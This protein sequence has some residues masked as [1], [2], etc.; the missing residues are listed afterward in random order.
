MIEW[1]QSV[2]LFI[3]EFPRQYEIPQRNVCLF[4]E[5]YLS[6]SGATPVWAEKP[7]PYDPANGAT[8][9]LGEDRRINPSLRRPLRRRHACVY[10]IK[11]S[12]QC[13]LFFMINSEISTI[14]KH[15][16]CNKDIDI[17]RTTSNSRVSCKKPVRRER[18][19][20]Q[21]RATTSVSQL[22]R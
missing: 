8:S 10:R 15:H 19:H 3:Q 5:L 16:L 18:P 7:E 20:R 12:A 9:A 4:F 1:P 21:T 2:F 11:S 6:I 13:F 17:S 22:H 14:M